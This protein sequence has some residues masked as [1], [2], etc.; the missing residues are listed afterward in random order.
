MKNPIDRLTFGASQGAKINGV[1]VDEAHTRALY[2][3]LRWHEVG[4]KSSV[5]A[6]SVRH[7][8]ALINELQ[9]LYALLDED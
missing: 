7:T 9:R 8:Q 4:K 1:E 5:G 2:D 6:S 3:A